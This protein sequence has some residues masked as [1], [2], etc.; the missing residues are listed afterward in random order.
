MGAPL[1]P[2]QQLTQPVRTLGPHC[3]VLRRRSGTR[4]LATVPKFVSRV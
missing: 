4:Q 3:A 2:L 1:S